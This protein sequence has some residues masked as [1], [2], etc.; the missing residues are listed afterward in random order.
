MRAAAALA[1]ARINAKGPE[2]VQALTRLLRDPSAEVQAAAG[3]ALSN[4]GKDAEPALPHLRAMQNATDAR[5]VAIGKAAVERISQA[6]N[7]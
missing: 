3:I 2:V 1:L 7:K 4:L 5:V 6:A